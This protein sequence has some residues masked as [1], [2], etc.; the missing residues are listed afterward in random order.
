MLL[1]G[2]EREKGR[3]GKIPGVPEQIRKIP[4]RSG[5]SQK[6]QK[7]TK[8]EGQVQIGKP[9]RLKPPRLA[10]LENTSLRR[11]KSLVASG[12]RTW[13]TLASHSAVPDGTNASP[14][15]TPTARFESQRNGC[16]SGRRIRNIA[17]GR[18]FV[19]SSFSEFRSFSSRKTAKFSLNFWPVRVH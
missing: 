10:A 19:N 1:I 2:L 18:G 5:K 12:Q 3:I 13:S 9:P 11:A 4:E 8:K 16:I 7:R 14:K 6:G 17:V 15:R